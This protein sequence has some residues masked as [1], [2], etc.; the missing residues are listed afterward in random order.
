MDA[1]I[2]SNEIIYNIKSFFADTIANLTNAKIDKYCFVEKGTGYT[3]EVDLM[4]RC[5]F[6][7]ECCNDAEWMKKHM[8]KCHMQTMQETIGYLW[9]FILQNSD[10][11]L[12]SGKEYFNTIDGYM[13]SE[14][15]FIHTKEQAVRQHCAFTHGTRNITIKRG[16]TRRF[17]KAF[18]AR[19]KLYE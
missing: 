11:A 15:G 7:K 2:P 3:R 12:L 1:I 16:V 14:C 4:I 13:C 17:I 18:F 6:C 8:K 19:K 10:N 9:T 5:P